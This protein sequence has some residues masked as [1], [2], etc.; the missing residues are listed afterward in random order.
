M[1]PQ[2]DPRFSADRF[3]VEVT[4]EAGERRTVE[5]LLRSVGAEEIRA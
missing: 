2:Y 1:S 3:G 5:D 4:C